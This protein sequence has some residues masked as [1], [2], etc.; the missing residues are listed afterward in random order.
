MPF[1]RS[2]TVNDVAASQVYPT[3]GGSA[4]TDRAKTAVATQT[5]GADMAAVSAAAAS[6]KP[7]HWLAVIILL[8]FALR[9]VAPALGDREDYKSIKVSLYNIILITISAI[10]GLTLFKVGVGRFQTLRESGL[11]QVILAA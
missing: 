7:A 11:G 10:V 8:I 3:A 5:G 6:A 1:N 9:F 2:N 4:A